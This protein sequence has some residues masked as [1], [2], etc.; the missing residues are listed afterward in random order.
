MAMQS[1]E[2]AQV[3]EAVWQAL[4]QE[5]PP[6]GEL[7]NRHSRYFWVVVPGWQLKGAQIHYE[8]ISR[9]G[10]FSAEFHVESRKVLNGRVEQLAKTLGDVDGLPVKFS[11]TWGSGQSTQA[12]NL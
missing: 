4:S 6:Y 9:R 2:S 5:Q 10:V 1:S 12:K 8:F 11:A 7:R 3:L